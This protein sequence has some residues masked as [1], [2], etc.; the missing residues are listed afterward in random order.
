VSS[1]LAWPH[2]FIDLGDHN[3][4]G[5]VLAA[6]PLLYCFDHNGKVLWTH[7]PGREVVSLQGVVFPAAYTV[8]LVG[9]LR[10]PRDDG[11]QI[12]VGSYRGPGAT[13][14]VELLT[15]GGHKVAEYYHFG[16]F[17][18]LKVAEFGKS[19]QEDVILTGVDSTSGLYGATLVILGPD[20]LGGQATTMVN[21][22][23]GAI[24]GVPPARE[25]AVLLIKEFFENPDPVQY[26]RGLEINVSGRFLEIFVAQ[27]SNAN[28]GAFFRFD[29]RLQLQ[30]IVSNPMLDA[31]FRSTI[32]KNLPEDQWQEAIKLFLGDIIYVR[33]EFAE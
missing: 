19:G 28:P 5:L 29:Q 15:K 12:I 21:S 16:W 3:H 18:A 17:F 22:P 9:A 20:H 32:L 11:G 8:S 27:G 2:K 23:L 31:R 7:R 30:G 24:Q 6:G 4:I 33:N 10:Q 1:S 14:V 13:F 25:K 26:C